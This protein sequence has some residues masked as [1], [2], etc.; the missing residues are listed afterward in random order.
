M[1]LQS[2]EQGAAAGAG[3]GQ[4]QALKNLANVWVIVVSWRG[5]Y[6]TFISRLR[7][8]ESHVTVSHADPE[9]WRRIGADVVESDP[10][11]KKQWPACTS[12]RRARCIDGSLRSICRVRLRGTVYVTITP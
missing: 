6:K 3:F 4:R 8:D 9:A 2:F 10:E 12:T 5:R 11:M 7:R 1:D